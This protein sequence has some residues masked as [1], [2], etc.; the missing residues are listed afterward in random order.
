MSSP[1]EKSVASS[2]KN[3]QP[4]PPPEKSSLEVDPTIIE[5]EKIEDKYQLPQNEDSNI[6][7]N[8]LLF[9]LQECLLSPVDKFNKEI[10]TKYDKEHLFDKESLDHIDIEINNFKISFIEEQ[11]RIIK[12]LITKYDLIKGLKKFSDEKNFSEE[13]DKYNI[14][15]DILSFIGPLSNKIN[16]VKDK[17]ND[18]NGNNN[19]IEKF[20]F[21]IL[22]MNYYNKKTVLLEESIKALDEQIEDLKNKNKIL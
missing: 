18:I 15:S 12:E 13:L 17:E 3:N 7:S 22:E 6:L 21:E 10:F 8:K 5:E 20:L 11:Y 9:L 1:N 14:N 4:S 16:E 19:E 2:P